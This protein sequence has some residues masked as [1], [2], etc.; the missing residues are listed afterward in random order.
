MHW[1]PI[2]Q[3]SRE[4]LWALLEKLGCPAKCVSIIRAFHDGMCARISAGGKLSD[5]FKVTNA[6]KQGCILFILFYAVIL[7][8]TM[9]KI[10]ARIYIRFRTTRKLFNLRRLQAT[11]KVV[12]E[13]IREL[14]QADDCTLFAHS[15]M[16]RQ[17][18]SDLISAAAV[19]FG[20]TI[21]LAKTELMHQRP[22]NATSSQTEV[23]IVP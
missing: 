13:L 23:N 21:N 17:E 12:E 2:P 22:P 1:L 11:T 18:M 4:A 14:L 15:E 16:K 9:S 3:V 19:S 10:T 8:E 5:P 20:L 6:V 7:K